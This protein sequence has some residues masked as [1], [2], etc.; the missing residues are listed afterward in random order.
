MWPSGEH[1]K[2]KGGKQ[3]RSVK[4][5]REREREGSRSHPMYAHVLEANGRFADLYLTLLHLLLLGLA[6]KF[7]LCICV[8]LDTIVLIRE[9]VPV[10]CEFVRVY[11]LCCVWYCVHV[12]V[13]CV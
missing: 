7:C 1:T 13:F 8:G 12:C 11:G 9:P 4:G 3:N 6:R 5:A 10:I 2:A